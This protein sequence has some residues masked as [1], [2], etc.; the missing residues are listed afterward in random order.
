MTNIQRLNRMLERNDEQLIYYQQGVG[1]VEPGSL[2]TPWGRRALMLV[3]SISA[4]MLRRHVTSAY[5]FLMA[6]HRNGDEIFAFGFSRGA[7]AVRV[8]AGMLSTVGLLHRGQEEL[9]ALAWRTYS[10]RQNRTQANEFR[11]AYSRYIPAIRMLGLFD[12]VSAVGMPWSPRVFDRT[13]SNRHVE[14]V[15]HALALDE[16]RA[17]FIQ[18][19]WRNGD[20]APAENERTTDVQQ[21]WF[22][23]NHCDIGGGYEAAEAG[24]SLISLIWMRDHAEQ[25][26][27]KFRP[28]VSERIFYGADSAKPATAEDI[29]DINTGAP[30]HDEFKRHRFWNLLE[31]LPFPRWRQSDDGSWVRRWR[32]HRHRARRVPPGSVLHSSVAIRM[33]RSG[34]VPSPTL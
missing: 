8:L 6:E 34:Y 32:C 18:N 3:D 14:I 22:A 27:L 29:A 19:L 20:S 10:Q 33:E 2:N 23:G 15:R 13:F 30:L 12:T 7:Y 5:R 25:A 1:T 16:R 11:N 28:K 26:G 31:W 4:V 21:V 24:A 17:M 9:I